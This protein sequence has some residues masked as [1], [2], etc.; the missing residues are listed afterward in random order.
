[1]DSTNTTVS[2]R[3]SRSR[4]TLLADGALTAKPTGSK[5]PS[6]TS[7]SRG[8]SP[9]ETAVSEVMT[10]QVICVAPDVTLEALLALMIERAISGVPVVNE[11]GLPIGIVSKTDLVRHRY[12][13]GN[14]EPADE[15]TVS[16]LMLPI[17]HTLLESAP[18]SHA[19]ALMA[20]EGV[21]RLPI[22]SEEGDV[23]GIL[24]ALDVVRWMSQKEGYSSRRVGALSAP[25]VD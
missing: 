23:V 25:L 12:E 3:S 19:A 22:C 21:H 13:N 6:A 5:Q 8:S 24:S 1:M 4:W 16:D 7:A 20:W 14:T 15:I 2:E 18:L 9:A 10:H 11:R 17:A